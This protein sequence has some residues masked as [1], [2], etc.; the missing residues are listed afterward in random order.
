MVK[1]NVL[2]KIEYKKP[3]RGGGTSRGIVCS[4]LTG[5]ATGELFIE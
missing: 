5:H 1:A 2:Q 3:A 4:N